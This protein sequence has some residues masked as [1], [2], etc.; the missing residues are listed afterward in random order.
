MPRLRL[1]SLAL[2]A[3]A[4]AG[5]SLLDAAPGGSGSA[6]ATRETSAAPATTEASATPS[7]TAASSDVPTRVINLGE[8]GSY[9]VVTLDLDAWD[10]RVDWPDDPDGTDLAEYIADHPGIAVLTNA[11]IFSDD[12]TPGGLLVADGE[13]RRALNLADGYGNFHLKPNAVFEIRDDGTAA[14]VDSTLYDPAGVAQATQSGP[15]LLLDGE[16]HP[17]FTEGSDNTALRTGVGVSPDGGTV[18]LAITR[19]YVNLW[20]FAAMFRDELGVEDALYLDGQISQ[21]WV[22][23]APDPT[24]YLGPYAGVIAAYPR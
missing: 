22:A 17:Q 1:A 10:V 14:I 13:E 18:Y 2:A 7:G 3:L 11:G 19:T 12:L 15:A 4:L 5:C 21:L 16:I 8:H 20:D 23:G 9:G 6:A 24:P